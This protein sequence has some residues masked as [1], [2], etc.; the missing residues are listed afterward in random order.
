MALGLYLALPSYDG[1]RLNSVAVTNA[2]FNR[3]PFASV[4][5]DDAGSS[6]LANN[7]NTMW[8]S[9]LNARRK[10]V[11]HFAML[12]ADVFPH[13]P[14][15]LADLLALMEQ[16]SADVLS[17]IVPIKDDRGLTSTALETKNPWCPRRLT[18]RELEAQAPTFT[19]PRILVNTGMMLVDMRR[20]WI[21]RVHFT[22]ND[23]IAVDDSGR[24]YAQ[25]EPEDWFFS[26]A[27]KRNGAT[28]WAT[29]ALAVTH[30]GHA[31]YPNYGGWGDL[32]TDSADARPA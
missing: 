7:F 9:A 28:L 2:L 31:R 26:R 6:L 12:H 24:F 16:T 5:T 14:T 18:I 29:R 20:P 13:S 27:A 8:A 21:E 11:T 3:G 23:A 17:A 32:D 25:V 15:W 10:G 30:L 22:V 1:S 19:D 4:A